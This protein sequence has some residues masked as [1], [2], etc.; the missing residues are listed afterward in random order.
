MFPIWPASLPQNPYA[1]GEPS[2]KPKP[3]VL[4]SPTEIGSPKGRRR[5]T[6]VG[7]D[8]DFELVLSRTQLATLRAFYHDDVKGVLPFFWINFETGEPGTYK[9]RGE[10]EPPSRYEAG[11]GEFWRVSIQLELQP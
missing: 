5:T 3:N 11:D 10:S 1:Y 2:Y 4:R 9:F 7:K 6:K 8:F